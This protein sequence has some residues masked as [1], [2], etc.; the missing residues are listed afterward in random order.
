MPENKLS[1]RTR[2]RHTKI[3]ATLG[4]ACWDDDGIK[5]LIRA[6]LKVFRINMA[7]GNRADH[8]IRLKAIR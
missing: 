3:V 2:L 1:P 4:P 7:H 6:G 8:E 5:T